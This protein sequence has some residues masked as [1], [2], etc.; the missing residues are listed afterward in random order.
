MFGL[1]GAFTIGVF[2]LPAAVIGAVVLARIDRA[3]GELLGL[4]SGLGIPLLYVGYLNRRGPGDVCTTAR[5]GSQSCIE[6]WSPWPWV[7]V[8]VLLILVGVVAFA[9]YRVTRSRV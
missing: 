2:V 6:E 8:G 1:L 9:K 7:A 3:G 5:D 4:I